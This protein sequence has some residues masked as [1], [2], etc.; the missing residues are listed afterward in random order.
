V[1]Q[2]NRIGTASPKTCVEL[3]EIARERDLPGRP[4]MGRDELAEAL[5]ERYIRHGPRQVC[6][7]AGT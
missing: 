3:Y 5:G 2:R 1:A 6:G 7:D 4:K